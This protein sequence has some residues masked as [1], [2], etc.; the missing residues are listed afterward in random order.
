MFSKQLTQKQSFVIRINRKFF[1]RPYNRWQYFYANGDGMMEM[2]M[3][4]IERKT[5]SQPYKASEYHAAKNTTQ[6]YYYPI[7][8]NDFRYNLKIE[9]FPLT[10]VKPI[11]QIKWYNN[12][13]FDAVMHGNEWIDMQLDMQIEEPM[14]SNH[15]IQGSGQMRVLYFIIY[16]IIF[17]VIYAFYGFGISD[18]LENAYPFRKRFFNPDMGLIFANK[19]DF[20][21][22]DEP[23]INHEYDWAI[24]DSKGN[25]LPKRAL[26]YP[27]VDENTHRI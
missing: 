11:K 10:Y 18:S 8:I 17:S 25:Y 16:T 23:G 20:K 27:F 21:T 2:E 13:E 24:T 5:M 14:E 22:L 9:N 7:H 4:D 15:Y 26:R 3:T 1:C 6:D 12:H 19:N